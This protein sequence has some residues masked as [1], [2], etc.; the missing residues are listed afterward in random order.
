MLTAPVII[1]GQI[2]AGRK[3]IS[4]AAID[5]TNM[6]GSANRNSAFLETRE[7]KI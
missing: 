1:L 6:P 2:T 3:G 7:D 5:A 4:R